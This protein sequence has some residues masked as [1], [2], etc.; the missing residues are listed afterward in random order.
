M[1]YKI[2]IVDDDQ[3][4]REVLARRFIQEGFE[5]STAESGLRAL[6]RIAFQKFDLILLDV[7]MPGMDGIET[8]KQIR[9]Q[10]Q[11]STIPV[12]ML[13]ANDKNDIIKKCL[14][15]GASDYLVKPF[16]MKL[17][18]N[19]IERCLALL[20]KPVEEEL[21]VPEGGYRLLVVDDNELNRRLLNRQLVKRGHKVFEAESGEQ[22][23]SLI[24]GDMFD[25]VLLDINMPG[26][27]GIEVLKRIRGN[28]K[29]E[30]L[31]VVIV[32]AASDTDTMVNC[33]QHGADDYIS[34]PLDMEFLLKRI[35]TVINARRRGI[36]INLG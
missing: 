35:M 29:T 4:N 31:P 30:K 15:L 16:V 10:E 2:L 23:L 8:L 26:I 27:S 24:D 18:R 33:I 25:L 3:L 11:W 20:N 14:S 34:K 13:S 1:S 7:D 36:T 9:V 21:P 19:R 6:E 32:T 12:V 17:A 28:P 22:A 5:A